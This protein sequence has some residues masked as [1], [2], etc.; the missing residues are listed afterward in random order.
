MPIDVIKSVCLQSK[1]V[2]RELSLSPGA[3]QI[4]T[5]SQILQ[6]PTIENKISNDLRRLANREQCRIENEGF[7][8]TEIEVYI[9][10][11]VNAWRS[12]NIFCNQIDE[13]LRISFNPK[14]QLDFY[15]LAEAYI[16][17]HKIDD[18]KRRLSSLIKSRTEKII[19]SLLSKT[20]D[21]DFYQLQTLSKQTFW[22]EYVTSHT[23]LRGTKA[24]RLIL[25]NRYHRGNQQLLEFRMEHD[26]LLVEDVTKNVNYQTS[27]KRKAVG[28]SLHDAIDLLLCI[29]NYYEPLWVKSLVGLPDYYLRERLCFE[30]SMFTGIE[31][32]IYDHSE[33]INAIN[34]VVPPNREA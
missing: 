7:P 30:I 18:E 15:K 28:D 13:L 4:Y 10:A 29:D 27:S 25:S 17:M 26:P 12:H 5:T 16:L 20:Q 14:K 1:R 9:M 22:V 32:D 24:G 3:E 11:L 31:P 21:K 2:L 8:D 6:N 33:I 23:K 19:E 34:E